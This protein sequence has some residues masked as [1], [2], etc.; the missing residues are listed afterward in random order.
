MKGQ[1]NGVATQISCLERRAIYTHCYGHSLNLAC[2]E[3]VREVKI[4]KDAVDTTFE[5]SKIAK[6]SAKR[7]AE[8]VRLKEERAH[9]DPGFRTICPTRWTVRSK[10]LSSVR[11]NYSVLQQSLSTFADFAKHDME[12]SAR[13]NGIRSQ[14]EKFSFLFGVMLGESVLGMAENLSCVLQ[15]KKISAAEVQ[16]A[17]ELTLDTMLKHRTDTAFTKFWDK[18]VKH[19]KNVDVDKP[20]LPRKRR[21]P[22]R[23]DLSGAGESYVPLTVKEHYMIIYYAAFD[24]VISSIKNHFDQPGYKVYCPLENVLLNAISGNDFEADIQKVIE[25]YGNDFDQDLLRIQL[26]IFQTHFASEQGKQQGNSTISDV[27]SLC[28]SLGEGR[29]VLS[30][31]EVL[32]KVLLIMPATNT[33]SE[34]S[35]SALRRIKNYLRSTMKQERLNDVMVLNVHKDKTDSLDLNCCCNDFVSGSEHIDVEFSVCSNNRQHCLG[36][37]MFSPGLGI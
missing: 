27:K 17:A 6:Y 13:V 34:R 24:R 28:L 3:T 15:S 4:V 32:L 31:I 36:V 1:R 7:K 33:S 22:A 20:A 12:I 25:V 11:Q 5:L 10:S 19:S 26:D 21:V 35:F 14:M 2:Q 23:F 16:A 18:V 30:Q 29:H 37:L 8:L 9:N